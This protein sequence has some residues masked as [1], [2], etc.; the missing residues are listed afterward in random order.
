MSRAESRK[1]I[2][3]Y[4]NC[5][6]APVYPHEG[7]AAVYTT[8]FFLHSLATE[9]SEK[10]GYSCPFSTLLSARLSRNPLGNTE[11]IVV[12]RSTPALPLPRLEFLDV[13][14]TKIDWP[15]LQNV[16]KWF[17]HLQ[18]L[19]VCCNGLSTICGES[20]TFFGRLETL[21]LNDN[22]IEDW[23]QVWKLSSLPKLETLVLSGNPLTSIGYNVELTSGLPGE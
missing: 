6:T 21:L 5:P 3:Y 22:A 19:Q 18:Q 10:S 23:N 13:T 2:N 17:P 16:G 12:P 11:S 9:K 7:D 20:M 14:D 8:L 4:P 1:D 15:D